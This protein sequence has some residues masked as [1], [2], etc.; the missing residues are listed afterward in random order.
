M[1]NSASNLQSAQ[2]MLRFAV[3]NYDT[4]HAFSVF[5]FAFF[6]KSIEIFLKKSTNFNL[7]QWTISLPEFVHQ[8]EHSAPVWKLIWQRLLTVFCGAPQ[9]TVLEYHFL[10]TS[11]IFPKKTGK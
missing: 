6:S 11:K 5:A 3:D 9:K 1:I 8:I 4:S 2:L 7:P 10:S